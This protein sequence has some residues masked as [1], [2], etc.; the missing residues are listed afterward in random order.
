ML[1]DNSDENGTDDD[2]GDAAASDDY[3]CEISSE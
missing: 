2:T 1:T 3:I